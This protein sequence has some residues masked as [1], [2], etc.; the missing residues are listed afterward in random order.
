MHIYTHTSHSQY[1]RTVLKISLWSTREMPTRYLWAV[2]TSRCVCGCV[3]TSFRCPHRGEHHQ[4]GGPLLPEGGLYEEERGWG[5]SGTPSPRWGKA[6]P[7]P[8]R[9][10][11]VALGKPP[12]RFRLGLTASRTWADK[13]NHAFLFAPIRTQS[14]PSAPNLGR[15]LIHSHFL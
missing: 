2:I 9:R 6:D 10:E 12:G 11:W 14:H 7:W 1:S 15:I 4:R 13:K 5:G 8:T 3:S